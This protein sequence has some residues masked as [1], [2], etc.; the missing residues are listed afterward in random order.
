LG[1]GRQ[2]RF[3]IPGF[4][5]RAVALDRLL[6]CVATHP[7]VPAGGRFVHLIARSVR[8]LAA[9]ENEA[10]GR[11]GI[12]PDLLNSSGT[13]ILEDRLAAPRLASGRGD[14]QER[15]AR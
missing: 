11:A 13:A 8:R 9:I 1:A 7:I 6:A 15:I 10:A 14:Q 12:E 4:A 5:G 2:M 3:R